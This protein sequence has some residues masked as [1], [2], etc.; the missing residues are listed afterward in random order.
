MRDPRNA[1]ARPTAGWRDAIVVLAGCLGLMAAIH[2]ATV[3]SILQS[4][5]RDPL[6]HGYF[7][8]PATACLAWICRDRLRDVDPRPAFVTLVLIAGLS[9]VWLVGNL[10]Q[11]T[12]LEQTSVILLFV[13]LTW[14]VLGTAAARALMFPLGVLLFALPVIERVA[15][16]LQEVTARMAVQALALSGV[17]A[18]LSGNV[19]AI[20]GTRWHVSEACG[21]INYLT[22]SL[23]VGYVYAGMVYRRWAHRLAFVAAAALTPIAGNLLRVYTTILLDYHGATGVASGMRHTLYGLLVF[24]VMI[25]VLFVTCGRWREAVVPELPG[26]NGPRRDGGVP[27]AGRRRMPFYATIAMLLIASGPASARILWKTPGS[28]DSIRSNVPIVGGPWA[29]AADAFVAWTPPATGRSASARAYRAGNRVVHLHVA[30]YGADEATGDLVSGDV[31][32]AD[33]RWWPTADRHRSIGWRDENLRVREIELRSAQESLL[34]W[35]WYVVSDQA[36]G[37]DYR[38]KLLLARER[39]LRRPQGGDRVVVFTRIVPD[40]DA[41]D[42]LEDFVSRLSMDTSVPAE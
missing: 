8:L 10:T 17:P 15:P 23:L 27:P 16:M 2:Y 38:A 41:V 26:S 9:F 31:T 34:V 39:F 18:A 36:T 28:A 20:P 21:G 37:D 3:A 25:A 19:I 24:T 13:A 11:T 32:R 40:A 1:I 29:P 22:A 42:A 4:W 6:A 33:S 7:V 35:Y 5:S 14:G 12:Q 30:S